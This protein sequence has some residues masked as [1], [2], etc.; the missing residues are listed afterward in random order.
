MK[1]PYW[2]YLLSYL[3]GFSVEVSGSQYNPYL[4]VKYSKGRYQLL[5]ENAIHSHEDLYLH[6]LKAFQIL[7]IDS[8]KL[9]NVL[10]LGLGL[11]SIPMILE[12]KMDLKLNY[13]AVELDEKVIHLANKYGLQDLQ[14]TFEFICTDAHLF[15]MQC[16]QRF[17][18]ICVDLFLDDI[19]PE[20][21]MEAD[22]LLGLRDLC[23]P[24][25]L[26]LFNCLAFTA[27]DRVESQR[28]YEGVFQTVFPDAKALDVHNNLILL[29]RNP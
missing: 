20:H 1:Q 24:E 3:Y 22:F 6:Y 28:F 16:E 15:V 8:L 19:I 27:D 26:I 21:F 18:M 12:N 14:S 29:N 10:L 9:D 17:D 25:A 7:E 13:T 23:S 11:G 4:E 2:K 5:T